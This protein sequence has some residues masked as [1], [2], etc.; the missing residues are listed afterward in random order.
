MGSKNLKAVAVKGTGSLPEVAIAV[1][2][3][4]RSHGIGERLLVALVDQAGQPGL[5]L[6]VNAQNP[7]HHLYERVGFVL[8]R[9]DGDR[10]T[11]VKRA[12]RVKS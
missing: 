7:A 11:M 1:V 8:V 5:S 2:P 4:E 10:L 12:A 6:T 3:E 9:R